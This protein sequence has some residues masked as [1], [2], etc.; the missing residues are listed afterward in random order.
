MTLA[1]TRLKIRHK[2]MLAVVLLMAAAG[3]VVVL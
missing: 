2:L 3:A 1:L